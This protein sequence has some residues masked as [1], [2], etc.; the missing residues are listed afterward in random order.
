MT[1]GVTTTMPHSSKRLLV[2]T[3][4]SMDTRFLHKVQH[5]WSANHSSAKL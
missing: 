2:G 4:S 5:F 1:I 3:G